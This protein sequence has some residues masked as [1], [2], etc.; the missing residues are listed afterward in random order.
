M[1]DLPPLDP[2]FG[3]KLPGRRGRNGPSSRR[4]RFATSSA[5]WARLMRNAGGAQQVVVRV[6]SRGYT[7]GRAQ[8][9]AAYL[10]RQGKLTGEDENGFALLDR[11]S[12]REKLDGWRLSRDVVFLDDKTHEPPEKRKKLGQTLHM[13]F[14]MPAG[15]DPLKVLQGV[16]QLAAVEF[17]RHEHIL[18]LHD[19]ATDPSK[20]RGKN[21]HVHVLL[22]TLSLDGRRLQVGKSELRYFREAFAEQMRSLGVEANASS[23]HERAVLKNSESLGSRKMW[24]RLVEEHGSIDEA[25]TRLRRARELPDLAMPPSSVKRTFDIV[26]RGYVDAIKHLSR[27]AREEDLKAAQVLRQYVEQFPILRATREQIDQRIE[28]LR[29]S[30][31]TNTPGQRKGRGGERTR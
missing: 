30:L 10:I 31:S 18:V 2:I 27:S 11:E 3:L 8:A 5:T 13:V 7:H 12:V 6:T 25:K 21:P 23:R 22:K 17:D 9:H 26:R 14:S 4:L 28:A 16:R 24:E 19:P 1:R 15:T 29:E 20:H